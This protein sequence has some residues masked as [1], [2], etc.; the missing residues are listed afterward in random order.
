MSVN[1][2]GTVKRLNETIATLFYIIAN[3]FEI[4]PFGLHLSEMHK[5][6]WGRSVLLPSFASLRDAAG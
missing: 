5:E 2:K 4:G 3:P 1:E 6:V